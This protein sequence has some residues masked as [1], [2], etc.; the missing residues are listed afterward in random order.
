MS[1]WKITTFHTSAWEV[2]P[3]HMSAWKVTTFHTSAGKED[4]SYVSRER[5]DIPYVRR[6]RNIPY[7]IMERHDIPYVIMERK[8]IPYVSM[9]SKESTC[10][11]RNSNELCLRNA[12]CEHGC[13]IGNAIRRYGDQEDMREIS[14]VSMES[15]CYD[16]FHIKRYAYVSM[17]IIYVFDKFHMLYIELSYNNANFNRQ[18]LFK[19]IYIYINMLVPQRH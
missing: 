9:E 19:D 16:A 10:V 3:F 18:N 8:Y 1:A 17:D 13:S 6:E 11:G 4:M 12:I 5:K 2:K 14:Y 7:V 15:K